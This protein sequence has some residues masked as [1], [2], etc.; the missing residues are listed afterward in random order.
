M[1]VTLK[2]LVDFFSRNIAS[3]PAAEQELL[4]Q[5]LTK[6]YG[7]APLEGFQGTPI[8]GGGGQSFFGV[9]TAIDPS[10]VLKLTTDTTEADALWGVMKAKW[11]SAPNVVQVFDVWKSKDQTIRNRMGNTVPITIA[12]TERLVD[13]GLK[14]DPGGR[15][16][17]VVHS[18]LGGAKDRFR[19]WP[20]DLIAAERAKPGG[21]KEKL[22]KAVDY[23]IKKIEDAGSPGPSKDV[24][25]GMKQLKKLKIY[26]V[27]LHRGNVGYDAQGTHKI[28]DMGVSAAPVSVISVREN[29]QGFALLSGVYAPKAK[30]DSV[31]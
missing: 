3:M 22:K 26:T 24:V 21:A 5:R 18:A 30:I 7:T 17:D 23:M 31:S 16:Q 15:A 11:G 9:A 29:P 25:A 12:V 28:L 27:D 19:V 14:D 6:I 1:A 4:V 20:D 10:T 2:Q 8:R 13:T